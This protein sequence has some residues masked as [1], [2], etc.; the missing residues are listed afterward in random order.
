M[1]SPDIQPPAQPRSSVTHRF[2][3]GRTVS[4]LILREMASRYG[5]SPGGY[6]WALLEP[7]GSIVLMAISFSL[8]VRSPP[9]G[10]SFM[11][12]FGTGFIPFSL[13]QSISNPV[14]RTL[15][16]SKALL[17]YPIITW[18]DAVLARFL[19]NTLT[20]VM[21]SYLMLAFIISTLDTPILINIRP[22][23]EAIAL[24]SLL[25]LGV[26]LLNCALV[27][28]VQVWEKFWTILTRPLFLASGVILRYEDMPKLVQDILW[29]NPLLHITGHMREA[30][31][32]TYE[33]TYFSATYVLTIALITSFFGIIL[34]YRF[35][36]QILSN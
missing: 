5:R 25:A 23:M 12:F 29:Y 24:C 14:S 34:L 31:Y 21:V 19:L 3:M 30:F 26:G 20:G 17:A 2:R 8:I 11:L 36:R 28:L 16:Y 33:A 13:Y 22:A 18:V 4:A 9:M 6:L 7:L 15:N 27:G 10:T 32:P 1:T 35:H